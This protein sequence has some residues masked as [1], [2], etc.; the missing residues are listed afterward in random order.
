MTS[1]IKFHLKINVDPTQIS[2]CHRIGRNQASTATKRPLIVKFCRRDTVGDLFG[3]CRNL[4]PK[5]FFLSEHL[6]PL[7]NKIMHRLRQLKK[8]VPNK[9]SGCRSMNGEPRVFLT[10]ASGERPERI[11]IVTR[12]QLE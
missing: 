4:K 6:T 9:I 11:T 5:Q 2:A 7:R 10:S 8:K 12:L 1:L 3:A